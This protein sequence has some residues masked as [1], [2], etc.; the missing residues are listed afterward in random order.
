MFVLTDCKTGGVYA[1][2][3]DKPSKELSRFSLTKM[4]QYVIMR[5]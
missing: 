3:D 2:R 5:C 4:M 1:V